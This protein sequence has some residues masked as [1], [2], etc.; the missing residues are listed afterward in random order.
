M[1]SIASLL[2]IPNLG[3]YAATKAY[4][5]SFSEALRAEL[6][7][8]G[9]S[10]THLCPGPIDTEFQRVAA[11]EAASPRASTRRIGSRSRWRRWHGWRCG[12]CRADYARVVPGFWMMMAPAFF[13]ALVPLFVLRLVYASVKEAEARR[14][15]QARQAAATRTS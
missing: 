3:V 7:G 6:R 13:F 1:S 14:A 4:V 10:V 9:I 15:T 11:R 12:R 5:S 2:P 8:T